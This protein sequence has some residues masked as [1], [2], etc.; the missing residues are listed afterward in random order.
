MCAFPDFIF[1]KMSTDKTVIDETESTAVLRDQTLLSETESTKMSAE[2]TLLTST[3]VSLISET[4]SSVS[5][6]LKTSISST[7]SIS[8]A[9]K[10]NNL[11]SKSE[12]NKTNRCKDVNF[13][14]FISENKINT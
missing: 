13:R 7:V 3:R 6:T 2:Q 12:E 5:T 1:V 14:L 4:R 8:T 9:I 11:E 10:S